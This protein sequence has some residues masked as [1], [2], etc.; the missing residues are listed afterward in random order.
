MRQERLHSWFLEGYFHDADVLTR[1][2]ID[3]LPFNIGRRDGMP[4]IKSAAQSSGLSRDH[5]DILAAEDD[6]LVVRDNNSTNG[7]F[8]NRVQIKA[9]QKIQHGDIIHFADVEARLIFDQVAGHP[10]GTGLTAA[11]SSAE[12]KD[13][14][15]KLPV[16]TRLF[17]E[18]IERKLIAPEFQPIVRSDGSPFAHELL[19]R[20]CHP[21]LE[22]NTPG[23]LFYLAES[24]QLAAELSEIMR[25]VGIEAGLAQ[26]SREKLFMNIHA[27]ELQ[28]MGRFVES[29]DGLKERHPNANLVLE[30]HEK[31]VTDLDTMGHLK[32]VLDRLKI[33]LAYDDFGAG[34]TRLMELV[35]VPPDY[36]KFDIMLVRNIHNANPTKRGMVQTLLDM[37]H[38]MGI[39]CLAECISQREEAEV[40]QAMGFDFIQGFYYGR[41][42]PLL[43]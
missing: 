23:A 15:G 29:L 12:I 8:V 6:Q 43:R 9:E 14:P 37:A 32:G 42:D 38:G 34:Q 33:E 17:Q 2:P 30:M 11:L 36:L 24:L 21:G 31:A 35:E 4:L 41:P 20:G 10:S 3:R 39:Q 22:N 7:T 1:V 25:D 19:G 5:A 13:L 16:G 26:N 27:A 18:L 40:C 28:D